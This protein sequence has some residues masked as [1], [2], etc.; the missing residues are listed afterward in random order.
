MPS[1]W[2]NGTL[3]D[4]SDRII[5]GKT[6]STSRKEYF[7]GNIPF[8]TI[9]DMHN[10]TYVINSERYLSEIGANSQSNKLLPPNSI[11][12]S[13]IAT[14]GL[15][16]ITAFESQTNQ[17][18]NSIVPKQ[19]ISPYFVYS[20]LKTLS[21]TIIRLGSGGSTTCNLNKT[22]F[23]KIEITM[24]DESVLHKYHKIMTPLFN[25]IKITQLERQVLLRLKCVLLPKL[26]LENSDSSSAKLS[27]I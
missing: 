23:S 10:N 2:K 11:C 25:K 6:P 12:V 8:I 26:M 22:Q 27:F 21:D 15:V 18:I 13:C 5:C 3:E 19:N 9:P 1:D 16:S 20:L 7:G 4:L 17:Q 24:P 14:A